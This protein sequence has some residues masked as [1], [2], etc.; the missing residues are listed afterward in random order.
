MRYFDEYGTEID[1]HSI[2][3]L[4]TCHAC[5]R[6]CEES[7]LCIAIRYSEMENADFVCGYFEPKYAFLRNGNCEKRY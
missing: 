5:T 7:A 4:P 6:E 2:P 1:P 3:K